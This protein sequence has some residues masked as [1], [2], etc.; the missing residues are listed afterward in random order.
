[1]RQMKTIVSEAISG[2]SSTSTPYGA[3]PPTS[4]PWQL[5]NSA[6]DWLQQGR[7]RAALPSLNKALVE[8]EQLDHQTAAYAHAKAAIHNE[9]GRVY[10][11]VSELE[12][13]EIEF[14]NAAETA[15]SVP[16]YRP[17][18]FDITYNLSTVLERK[19]L[20][21]ESCAQLRRTAF[22]YVD[23]LAH[24]AEPPGG[25]GA[26]GESFLRDVAGPRIQAR[27]RRIGCDI[28]LTAQPSTP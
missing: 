16:E 27:A 7:P 18:H 9:L 4:D 26:S 28:T 15:T 12:L 10:A 13:A 14:Q 6:R 2:W 11:M 21:A 22:I 20:T 24:P 1:M 8:V 23:L 5:I 17:L 25:Y 19:G 3:S